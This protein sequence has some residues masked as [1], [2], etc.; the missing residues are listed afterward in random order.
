MANWLIE[1]GLAT[2]MELELLTQ[3]EDKRLEETFSEVLAETR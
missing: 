2:A 3:E 1:H